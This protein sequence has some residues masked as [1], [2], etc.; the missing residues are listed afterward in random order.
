MRRTAEIPLTE[1]TQE[2]LIRHIDRLEIENNLLRGK[3]GEEVLREN[4]RLLANVHRHLAVLDHICT[5]LH[6]HGFETPDD[7][8]IWGGVSRMGQRMKSAEEKLKDQTKET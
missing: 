6:Y 3:T 5:T 8:H 2:Q 1:M 4:E 7:Q